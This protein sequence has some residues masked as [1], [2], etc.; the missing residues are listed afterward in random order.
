MARGLYIF[1]IQRRQF[2]DISKDRPKFFFKFDFFF[3]LQ[4]E[5]REFRD[6]VNIEFHGILCKVE[7]R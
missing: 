7:N 5:T 4:A 6:P 2:L 3:R 1:C